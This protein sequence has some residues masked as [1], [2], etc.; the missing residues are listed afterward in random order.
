M[1]SLTPP[2]SDISGFKPRLPP[3][4]SGRNATSNAVRFFM[5][6]TVAP[7]VSQSKT[8]KWPP[9]S[10]RVTS[11]LRKAL[12]APAMPTKPL[13]PVRER[14][15]ASS[16]ASPGKTEAPVSLVRS[17][18]RSSFSVTKAPFSRRSPK[19]AFQDV[20]DGSNW[21]LSW[22]RGTRVT[23]V[24]WASATPPERATKQSREESVRRIQIRVCESG[25]GEVP[26]RPIGRET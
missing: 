19:R 12:L 8:P 22:P 5:T 10:I 15:W 20:K 2:G 25:L 26:K 17:E 3:M 7:S 11:W 6:G 16:E 21:S 13:L 24:T 18:A 4:L 1:K 9:R 14:I 23:S